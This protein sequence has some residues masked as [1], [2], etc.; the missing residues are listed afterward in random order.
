MAMSAGGGGRGQWGTRMGFILAAAGSAVGLGNIWRF[1]YV[2]GENGGGLFVLIYLICVVFVGLPIMIAEVLMGRAAAATPVGSFGK[3]AKGDG[4]SPWQLVGWLGVVTGF[5]ILSY[6]AVVAGWVCKYSTLAIVNSFEGMGPEEISGV[7]GGVYSSVGGN[8]LWMLLFMGLSL[9]VILGGVQSGIERWSRI[10]LPVMFGLMILL[11]VRALTMEGAGKALDFVFMPHA[12]KM[13][14]SS[15][16]EAMGQAFF[17]LSLGMGAMLT[18]GSYLSRRANIVTSS[19]W[20][21]LLDTFVALISAVIIFPILFTFVD[22]PQAGPGLVFETMPILFAQMP[23]GWL[24][25]VAF[26][27][28]LLLAALTSAIS[29]L[30]VVTA[31]AIDTIG[32]SRKTAAVVA[33]VAIAVLGIPSALAGSDTVFGT[34]QIFD[35]NFFDFMDYLA[36]NWALPLGG[37]LIAVF[38]SWFMNSET[39]RREMLEGTGSELIGIW[40]TFYAVWLFLLRF[41][42]PVLVFLVLLNKIGVL[43]TELIDR[44][45]SGGGEPPEG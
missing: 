28:L 7:F 2:A 10:L 33:T 23:M 30:E 5:I 25:S 9:L 12:D 43:P 4:W 32:M 38:V 21:T 14:P 3:L 42:V 19:G 8:L 39:R 37:L 17:S 44:M 36:A 35:K 24:I 13:R 18:Y 22:E 41:V 34:I 1:P 6:Y 31:T 27:V 15:V 20:I 45:I 16:L 26:F 11:A 40:T 29:L